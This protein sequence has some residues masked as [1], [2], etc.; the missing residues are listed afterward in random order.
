MIHSV[1][2]QGK[3][4]FIS[5]SDHDYTGLFQ[6]AQFGIE[7]FTSTLKPI[8]DGLWSLRSSM[9]LKFLRNGIDSANLVA[10][11]NTDGLPNNWNFFSLKFLYSSSRKRAG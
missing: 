5:S 7:R 9:A 8:I 3:V 10:S 11:H 2:A 6:G 4:R 1:G